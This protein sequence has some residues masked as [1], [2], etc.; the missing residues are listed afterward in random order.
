MKLK[1]LQTMENEINPIVEELE[2]TFKESK[3]M[4]G[5]DLIQRQIETIPTLLEP[6]L[7]CVGSVAFAGTS[8]VGKSTILRQLAIAVS[9]HE[10]EFLGWKLNIKHQR[11]L[12]VSTEDFADSLTI[13]LKKYNKTKNKPKDAYKNI[14]F[15]CDIDNLIDAIE[16]YVKQN[17]IDLLI[18]DAYLDIFTGGNM[19]NDGGQVRQF[20]TQYDQLANKY[21]F[22]IIW[23]H[24]TKKGSKSL[25][26]DKDLVL[27]SQSFEAKMR[28]VCIVAEDL[29]DDDKRHLCF[30]KGNYLPPEH[31]I[32]SYVIRHDENMF[33]TS[34]G[35]RE[36]YENLRAEVKGKKDL[37]DL[38]INLSEENHSA[39]EIE[40]ELRKEGYKISK[41]TIN[42]YIN[43][44][45]K[46]NLNT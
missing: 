13:A 44:H 35:E 18:L 28:L 45:K 15:I 37:H 30:V 17:P 24:H 33:F 39:R 5:A 36:V 32:E 9:M 40:K 11:V 4:N 14:D 34:T 19:K 12:V 46:N 27:G 2:E 43:E 8:D 20:L 25:T 31:K 10:T 7:P 29:V 16:N 3:I 38:V 21:K 42:R 6:I 41:S 22:L 26:V 23:N 1:M